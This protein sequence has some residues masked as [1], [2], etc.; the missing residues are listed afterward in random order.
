MDSNKNPFALT[1]FSIVA[2]PLIA[3]LCLSLSNPLPGED[4][5]PFSLHWTSELSET[6]SYDG[7]SFEIENNQ[8]NPT[9][10]DGGEPDPTEGH[11]IVIS[12]T[13]QG[14]STT[15]DPVHPGDTTHVSGDPGTKIKIIIKT[16]GEKCQYATGTHKPWDP[17]HKPIKK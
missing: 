16:K 9:A 13:L 8:T 6:I 11:D 10:G 2:I 4:P 15:T 7:G 1:V 14:K 12:Y 3:F 17:K 5:K